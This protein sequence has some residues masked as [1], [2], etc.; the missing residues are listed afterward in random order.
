MNKNP[1]IF[2]CIFDPKINLFVEIALH[3]HKE[4]KTDDGRKLRKLATT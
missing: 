2:K 3:R 4:R 1:T